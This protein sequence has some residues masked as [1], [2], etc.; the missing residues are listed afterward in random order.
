M[1]EARR[2][3][4]EHCQKA[5]SINDIGPETIET[6]R[7]C[8]ICSWGGV[9]IGRSD[10]RIF[11]HRIFEHGA[12]GG[13][14]GLADRRHTRVHPGS[15]VPLGGDATTRERPPLLASWSDPAAP[16]RGQDKRTRLRAAC[17]PTADVPRTGLPARLAAG[18]G[19]P[20]SASLRTGDV[21]QPGD[22][23]AILALAELVAPHLPFQ[24]DRNDA[25]VGQLLPVPT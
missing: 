2:R 16:V 8:A 5:T 9:D 4:S 14:A 13:T 24:R 20:P 19:T 7:L 22:A 12:L 23:E 10:G 6:H 1:A 18:R 15:S 3:L 11:E 17:A 25:A 21:D